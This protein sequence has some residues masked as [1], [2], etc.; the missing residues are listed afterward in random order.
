MG[1][2]SYRI[3]IDNAQAGQPGDS[4]SSMSK[5]EGYRVEGDISVI[6][7]QLLIQGTDDDQAKLATAKDGKYVGLV[8]FSNDR[9]IGLDTNLPKPYGENDLITLAVE[10]DWYCLTEEA[11]TKGSQVFV[12][13]T[14]GPGGSV[15]GYC[16]TDGDPV[17][18][19]DTAEAIN[20]TFAETTTAAGIAKIKLSLAQV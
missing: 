1:Q 17:S 6:P 12:R 15:S 11:V 16:R 8:R 5:T 3:N 9:R 13:F 20:A 7:G 14:S 18:T 2:N 4:H 10:E 19:V